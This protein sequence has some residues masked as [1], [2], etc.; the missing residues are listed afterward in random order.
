MDIVSLEKSFDEDQE[1]TVSQ[2]SDMVL[3]TCGPLLPS[4]FP[5]LFVSLLP[6]KYREYFGPIKRFS[7]I[8][9]AANH[10]LEIKFAYQVGPIFL[11]G[12]RCCWL[13]AGGFADLWHVE[14]YI[15]LA[16]WKGLLKP[17][18]V[19][20]VFWFY[21][22]KVQI[23]HWLWRWFACFWKLLSYVL[24]CNNARMKTIRSWESVRK[25]R[26]SQHPPS[27]QG[28]WKM[29]KRCF[30]S[31]SPWSGLSEVVLCVLDGE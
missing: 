9:R 12:R 7:N 3:L 15:A 8:F 4:F 1:K 19:P 5:F 6:I 28:S 17:H 24:N 23:K 25:S 27:K 21:R 30:I 20:C 18:V 14:D 13:E 26:S 10:T 29:L 22:Y 31:L 16:Y 11:R 2:N